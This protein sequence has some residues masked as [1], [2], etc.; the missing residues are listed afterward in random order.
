MDWTVIKVNDLVLPP[1]KSFSVEASY[2]IEHEVQ[3]SYLIVFLG[4]E[5]EQP[6]TVGEQ[7]LK[8]IYVWGRLLVGTLCHLTLSVP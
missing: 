7:A 8:Q 3:E 5:V 1:V 2:E 4:Q 6:R